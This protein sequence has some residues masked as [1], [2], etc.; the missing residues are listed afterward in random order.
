MVGAILA[1]LFLGVWAFC[2]IDAATT[3]REAVRLLPK[4]AWVIVVVL[5]WVPGAVL[6]LL[7]GRPRREYAVA[8]VAPRADTSPRADQPRVLGPEDA[9]DFEERMRRVMRPRPEDER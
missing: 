4:L 7:L 1:L 8:D 3:P 6:W 9:P 5:L 2:L